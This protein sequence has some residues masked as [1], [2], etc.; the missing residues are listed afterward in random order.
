MIVGKT[1]FKNLLLK[2]GSFLIK[3]VFIT[4]FMFTS[5]NISYSAAVHFKYSHRDYSFNYELSTL[6]AVIGL[7]FYVIALYLL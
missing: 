3:E 4:L 7:I 5:L 6:G 2:I 1:L